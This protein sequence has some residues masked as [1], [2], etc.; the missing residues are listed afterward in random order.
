MPEEKKEG[1][2]SKLGKSAFKAGTGSAKGA[3]IGA[4]SG[5]AAETIKD[6]IK[7]ATDATGVTE[8]KDQAKGSFDKQ[9]KDKENE[10][11]KKLVKEA[12]KRSLK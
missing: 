6:G 10:V 7:Q 8:K 1:K 9:L 3:I 11:K 12:L 4:V 2:F 5:V